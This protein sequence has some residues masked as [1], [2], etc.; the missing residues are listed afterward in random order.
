LLRITLENTEQS[1]KFELA[2]K[3]AGVWVDELESTWRSLLGATPKKTLTVDLSQVTFIDGPGRKL[4]GE[5]FKQGAEFRAAHLMTKYIIEEI[6][7]S[8]SQTNGSSKQTEQLSVADGKASGS[9]GG[10]GI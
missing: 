9:R 1:A 10:K 7:H 8:G 6:I 4:L 3:L 2:G 5:M